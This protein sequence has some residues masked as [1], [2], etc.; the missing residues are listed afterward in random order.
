MPRFY[1]KSKPLIY[2]FCDGES[3]QVYT[4]FLKEKFSDVAVIRHPGGTG[5]FEEADEKFK[6]DARY[7]NNVEVTDEIWFF[8]DVETIDVNKWDKRYKI[9]KRLRALRKRDKKEIKVRLLMTTGCIEYWLLL[10]YKMLAPSIRT[11][12]E[13]ES[14]MSQVVRKE[15]AY[16]KGDKDSTFRIAEKYPVA[17]SN[18]RK[19]VKNLLP[20]G[21]PTVEDTD[22]RNE[23][24]YKNCKTFS[25]VYEA[26]DYLESLKN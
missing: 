7:R 8:F 6:K 10:H 11:V 17:V 9:I 22:E 1:K 14:I 21:L 4:D 19:T 3:E 18:A 20:D 25:T 15:P 26:I 5:I 23:W 12:A 16:K 24:L 13:K 2:V